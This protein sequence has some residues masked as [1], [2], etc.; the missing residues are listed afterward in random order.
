MDIKMDFGKF[1]W[2]DTLRDASF[3]Y[4]KFTQFQKLK[5]IMCLS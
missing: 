2:N 5:E 3:A 4:G 1:F